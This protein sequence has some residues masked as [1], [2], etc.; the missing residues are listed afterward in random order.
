MINLYYFKDFDHPY[1]EK[2]K[3]PMWSLYNLNLIG[4]V[5]DQLEENWKIDMVKNILQ[6]FQEKFQKISEKDQLPSGKCISF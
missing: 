6:E 4:K 3:K 2:G 1:L 5:V